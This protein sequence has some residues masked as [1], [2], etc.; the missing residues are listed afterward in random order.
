MRYRLLLTGAFFITITVLLTVKVIGAD[1]TPTGTW[2]NDSTSSACAALETKTLSKT[3]NWNITWPDGHAASLSPSGTGQCTFMVTCN[4]LET[5]QTTNCWPDFYPPV[6]TSTG[7]FNILVVNKVTERVRKDCAVP[8]FQW[9]QVFCNN[10]GERTW[11][12]DPPHTCS[13]C[14]YQ[15]EERTPN[16]SFCDI[17]A[18]L[19]EDGVNNDCDDGTDWSDEGC[20]CLSPIVIDTL[21]NGF[22]LTSVS[23]GVMFDIMNTGRPLQ[24]SWIQGDD[25]WLVLDRNA[26]GA[27]DNGTE[28]FGNFTPQPASTE[29]N[30]FLALAEYDKPANGG[31]LDQLIDSRDAIFNSLRLWQDTNH[32]GFSESNELYPLPQLNVE[33]ISLKYKESRR[34]DQYGNGFR[35]RAKVDDARQSHVTR[36]AWDVFLAH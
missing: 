1:C 24:L 17:N 32:N 19:C 15:E 14:V 8:L 35:Y 26:N 34:M 2:L 5:N 31:N 20:I 28:L 25:A 23:D 30:G 18:P 9:D 33:A 13:S 29:K 21:G 27:V 4:P 16:Y 6:T 10:S 7:G 11:G 12:P 36:W 3:S 22:D